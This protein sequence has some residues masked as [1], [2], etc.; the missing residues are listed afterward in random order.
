MNWKL[1]SGRNVFVGSVLV[2]T[3]ATS[4]SAYADGMRRVE[5]DLEA[6]QAQIRELQREVEA[7]K[8]AAKSDNDLKVKWKG[9]PELSSKDGNFK[10]KVR[11]RIQTDYNAINQDRAITGSPSVSALELRRAR[12]GVQGTVWGDVD[13][14]LEAD[15]A[16]DSVSMKDAYF[17][18]TGWGK[19]F[20]VQI[21]NFKTFNSLEHLTSSN[22]IEFLERASFVEAF[23]LDRQLGIGALLSDKH[24]TVSAGLFG[25]T[26][27]NEETWFRDVKTG[28][29]RATF[30]PINEDG[31]VLHFGGSW[32]YRAGAT[33]NR[34]NVAVANDQFFRYRARGADLHLANRFVATPQIFDRDTFWGLE[35][36]YVHGPWSIQGEYTQL[37]GDVSPLFNGPDSTYRGWYVEGSWFLTGETRPYKNGAFDRVKVLN[38]VFEGGHGAWQLAARYDVLNLGDNATLIPTCTMCGEQKTWQLGVNWYL[39]DNARLMFNY[40]QSD[41]GGG[42]IA[43]SN[44]NDGATIKGFG[45][46]AQVDW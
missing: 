43:G 22:Y 2:S 37:H 18:Y 19:H 38:P 25:P 29:A 42:N 11:G 12:L 15:F 44:R 27:G 30:A 20:A 36:A 5:A 23:G 31:H 10:M 21:G 28:S 17:K 14:I 7:T 4:F 32:R 8:K 6:M 1:K 34:S 13:Y 35:A 9:A 16:N 40:N 46:R 45:A 24:Y 3:L 39:N 26:T 41:I 33:E